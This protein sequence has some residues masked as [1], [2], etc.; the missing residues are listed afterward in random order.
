MALQKVNRSKIESMHRQGA[1]D[2]LGTVPLTGG[3]KLS[4]AKFRDYL[5]EKAK[6]HST[7]GLLTKAVNKEIAPSQWRKRAE[8]VKTFRE[9]IGV[10][11]TVREQ[12]KQLP[13]SR[14][15][16]GFGARK[17]KPTPIKR[18]IIRAGRVNWRGEYE[19]DAISNR[20]G[21]VG[22]RPKNSSIGIGSRMEQAKRAQ[23]SALDTGN[24]NAIGIGGNN[25]G[26]FAT[27]DS[28]TNK[29]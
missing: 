23:T 29:K 5:I 17:A 18:D 12:T 8:L 10:G 22:S 2:K 27:I 20:P 14:S 1:F 7:V 15:W 19:E 9:D 28:I 3:E 26:G 16:F 21:M 4:G 25:R 6:K 13:D 24:K 11:S